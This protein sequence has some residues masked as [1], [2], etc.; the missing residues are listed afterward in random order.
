MA[1]IYMQSLNAII[2]G[3]QAS[4]GS[5]GSKEGGKKRMASSCE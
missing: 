3:F 1:M 2:S 4:A 5:E